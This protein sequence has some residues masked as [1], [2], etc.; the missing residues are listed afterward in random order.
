MRRAVL[1]GLVAAAGAAPLTAQQPPDAES[2]AVLVAKLEQVGNARIALETRRTRGA[3]YAA[4]AVTEFVQV[5]SDGNRIVRRTTTRLARDSEGRTRRE[6]IG[7]NGA[8][9]NIVI[10]DP[11][12]GHNY[13]LD[14]TT[15]TATRGG[16]FMA[17]NTAGARGRGGAVT[18]TEARGG[19]WTATAR[20]EA[21]AIADLTKL[22]EARAG[23]GGRGEGVA[24]RESLGEQTVEGVTATGTR[25]TTT[26]AAGAVGNEQPITIV[27]EQWY[28][29]E[30]Q[31]LVLTKHNDPR[32]GET[33]YRV[34]DQS[35]FQVPSDYTLRSP[36]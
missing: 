27:S 28:S 21:E 19:T 35:L 18:V 23:R 1:I 11:V 24:N 32:A 12:G 15:H 13:V 17:F 31:M 16:A 5:L 14:P 3:P 7:A 6:T 8:V 29:S 36:Q 26:I 34:P 22:V 20:A 25:T 10:T 30:L 33:V 9:E 4:E 2:R